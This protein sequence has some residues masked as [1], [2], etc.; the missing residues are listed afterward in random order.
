MIR[1]GI[2]Q[3]NRQQ[4]LTEKAGFACHPSEVEPSNVIGNLV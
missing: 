2:S 4:N 1:N 3:P